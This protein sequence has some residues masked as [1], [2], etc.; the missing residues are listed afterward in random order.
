M[1][2]IYPMGEHKPKHGG[3]R[4][5]MLDYQYHVMCVS[6]VVGFML[7]GAYELMQ[8]HWF[9]SRLLLLLAIL[10]FVPAAVVIFSHSRSVG[11]GYYWNASNVEWTTRRSR[12]T[13]KIEV[14]ILSV[15]W[16]LIFIFIAF[17]VFHR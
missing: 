2:A 10:G 15:L 5:F 16:S 6:L 3:L 1:S 9:L 14:I 17:V 13:E 7:V 4:R 12:R 8:V 11:S